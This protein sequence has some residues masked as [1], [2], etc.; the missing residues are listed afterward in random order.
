MQSTGTTAPRNVAEMRESMMLPLNRDKAAMARLARFNAKAERR[1]INATLKWADRLAQDGREPLPAAT[2]WRGEPYGK[3]PV[4]TVVWANRIAR[5]NPPEAFLYDPAATVQDERAA[6]STEQD[7]GV[8]ITRAASPSK[9][10][11]QLARFG[12]PN[13][14]MGR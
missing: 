8:R 7:G 9:A 12:V 14:D 2:W 3:P 5:A 11:Q 13:S 6:S 10:R 1:S 4:S